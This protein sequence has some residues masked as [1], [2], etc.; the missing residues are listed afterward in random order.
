MNYGLASGAAWNRL[1]E[2]QGFGNQRFVDPADSNVGTF[3]SAANFIT[4]YITFSVDKT[5]LG[6]TPGTG[7]GFIVTLTRQDGTH[8]TD[9]T[10]AF[11]ATPGGYTFGV[12]TNDDGTAPCTADPNAVPKTMDVLTPAGVTQADELNYITHNPVVLR[13]VTIP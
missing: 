8:G 7:W 9:Q 2:V 12:C 1:I 3:T 6:G 13:D 11:T 4:R 5:A 10:R